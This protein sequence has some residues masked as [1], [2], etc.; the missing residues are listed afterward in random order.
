MTERPIP[1]PHE[2]LADV[3]EAQRLD[4]E[5]HAKPSVGRIEIFLASMSFD[6]LWELYEKLTAKLVQEVALQKAKL[7]QLLREIDS[8]KITTQ[9]RPKRDRAVK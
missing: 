4:E 1:A 9:D 5:L 2:E 8:S 6:E 7:E 3:R